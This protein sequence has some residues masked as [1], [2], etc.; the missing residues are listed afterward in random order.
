MWLNMWL[1]AKIINT[2]NSPLPIIY[3]TILSVHEVM[4]KLAV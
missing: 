2:K 1:K 4:S 3:L